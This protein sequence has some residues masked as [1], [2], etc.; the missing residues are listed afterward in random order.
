MNGWNA[1]DENLL[2]TKGDNNLFTL[3]VE[4]EPGNYEFK[5]IV[6]GDWTPDNHLTL[7]IQFRGDNPRTKSRATT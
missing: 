4:L 5:Y 6:D 2:F 1:N 7:P 3:K